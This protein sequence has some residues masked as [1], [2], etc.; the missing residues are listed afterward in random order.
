MK[1][2]ICSTLALA[3]L[4]LARA[5]AAAEPGLQHWN[6]I[7]QVFSHPRCA[8]C[9]VDAG[10][11]P[12]W[13][14]AS[15]GPQARAHGMNVKGGTSRIGA[16]NGLLCSTC[17]THHNSDLPNGPP[18]AHVWLLAPVSMQ[19]WGKTSA[20]ICAQI[21]DP[22][23]NGGRTLAEVAEHVAK[24]ELVAWGWKPGPGRER[25]PYS[26]AETATFLREWA[27]QGAPCPA[28]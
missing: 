1:T 18:G 7:H 25:A 13:S 11:I 2:T 27:A 22:A 28:P 3:V 6:K 9:H 17:H 15:Y 24:D 20:Q 16:E 23:R 12:I 8:N 14:G 5:A 10:G 26:A 4:M 19:W 21:K